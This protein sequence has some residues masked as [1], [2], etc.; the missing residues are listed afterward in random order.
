MKIE[1][2]DNG[3]ILLKAETEFEQEFIDYYCPHG[4][5]LEVFKKCGITPSHVIGLKIKRVESEDANV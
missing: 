4:K 1:F 5:N 3:D 2:D